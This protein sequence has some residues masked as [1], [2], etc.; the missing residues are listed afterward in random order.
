MATTKQNL[1]PVANQ[2]PVV[3]EVDARE[4]SGSEWVSRFPGSRSSSD[5]IDPFR[6]RLEAFIGAMRA[7]GAQVS[8]EATF[9]PYERAYLMHWAWCIVRRGADPSAVPAM[10]GVNIRWDHTDAD[11]KYSKEL[12]VAAAEKM[13]SGYRMQK[14]RVAPALES[15]H[16]ARLAVDMGIQ[17]K[18]NLVI[19]D[20]YG[21]TVEICTEPRTGMNTELHVVGESYGIIKFNRKGDD[22]PHW[23][24]TGG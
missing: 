1:T 15:Q 5:L 4:L 3:V 7:G 22:F 21:E 13:L 24:S 8:I 16:T 6:G 2:T 23:S 18:G 9:R 12:S 11:D 19:V 10:K 14:L 20:A 17:W